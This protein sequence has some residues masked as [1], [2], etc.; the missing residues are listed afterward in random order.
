MFYLKDLKEKIS[1]L[2]PLPQMIFFV[3]LITVFNVF[4]KPY[5]E[6]WKFDR[7]IKKAYPIFEI[8]EKASPQEYKDY[9]SSMGK[10]LA[11]KKDKKLLML[12]THKFVDAQ[13]SKLLPVADNKFIYSMI[14]DTLIFYKQ[15]ED[16]S[17]IIAFE[18]PESRIIDDVSI[19]KYENYIQKIALSKYSIIKNGLENP[20]SIFSEEQFL[21]AKKQ[22][23]NIISSLEKKYGSE[24]VFLLFND[25]NNPK[26]NDAIAAKILI[27]LYQMILALGVDKTGEIY[28]F[29]YSGERWK[30]EEEVKKENPPGEILEKIASQESEG[31]PKEIFAGNQETDLVAVRIREYVE[32]QMQ[33]YLPISDNKSIYAM[34]RE[35]LN[36]YKKVDNPNFIIAAEFP[37]SRSIDY[38]TKFKYR[39]DAFKII[40]LKYYIIKHA[41][42]N[43]QPPLSSGQILSAKKQLNNFKSTLNK[44]YGSENVSLLFH[45]TNNPKLNE[46]LSA[47]ILIDFHQKILD[48]GVDK[49]GEI[50]KF[51][52]SKDPRN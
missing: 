40:L 4:C 42:E 35:T 1:D 6:S 39:N 26:L 47:K 22:L 48:L 3:V 24:N 9:S 5:Y 15:V 43:P 7:E 2:Y 20:Q 51:L 17:I 27:N 34:A 46:A 13:M 31:S 18:F 12:H 28:K 41:L 8:L 32:A 30:F 21:S 19:K 10:M 52:H 44:K 14:R 33:K 25:T 11:E 50:F 16:P 45:D 23:K 37:E 36:L 49:A 29:I 38:A